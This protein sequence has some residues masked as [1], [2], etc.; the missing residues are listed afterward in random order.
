M[1]MAM[2][3]SACFSAGASLTPSPVIATTWPFSFH[4]LHDLELIH[5]RDARIDGHLLH[6]PS[7]RRLVHPGELVAGQDHVALAEDADLLRHGDCRELVVA[8]DHHGPD[9]APAGRPSPHRPPHRAAGPSCRRKPRNTRS[10]ST[11]SSAYD[12]VCDE[13]L[14]R[15]AENAQRFVRHRRVNLLGAWSRSAAYERRRAAAALRMTR[16]APARLR[17]HLS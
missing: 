15:D 5:G 8:G 12:P 2:P 3:M 9:A 16:S 1:P 10:F 14:V 7:K 4:A 11:C 17:A 6:D 13:L